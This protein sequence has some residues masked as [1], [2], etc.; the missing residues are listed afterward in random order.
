M[1]CFV[2]S[3]DFLM[4]ELPHLLMLEYFHC[5]KCLI[6]C[7]YSQGTDGFGPGRGFGRGIGGRM[8]GGRG[9]G[10]YLYHF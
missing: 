6:F 1:S 4:V 9:F 3:F 7:I 5:P 8:M 2:I 10:D